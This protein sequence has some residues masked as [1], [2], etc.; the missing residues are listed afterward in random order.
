MPPANPG[1]RG[2][3]AA[4]LSALLSVQLS[5]VGAMQVAGAEPI[6]SNL[7]ALGVPPWARVTVGLVQLALVAALWAR[8]A[9]FAAALALSAV[10]LGAVAVHVRAGEGPGPSLPAVVTLLLVSALA[11]ARRGERGDAPAT[12]GG[13]R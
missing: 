3:L 13:A 1:A 2:A 11:Y 8:R 9:R 12:P 7:R 4:L 5:V 10:L 6:A